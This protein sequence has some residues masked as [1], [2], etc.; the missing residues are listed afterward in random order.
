MFENSSHP[1][2]A[3]KGSTA[4]RGNEDFDDEAVCLKRLKRQQKKG[5]LK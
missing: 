2:G 5:Y 4:V 1:G 3:L